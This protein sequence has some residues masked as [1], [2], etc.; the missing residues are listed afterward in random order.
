LTR[1][2]TMPLLEASVL[3]DRP[4]GEVWDYVTSAENLPVWVPVVHEVTKITD[5]PVGVGTQWQ[6]TMRFLGIGFTGLVE[7]VQCEINKMTEFKSVESK[8]RFSCTITFQEVDGRTRFTYRTETASGF[9]GIFGKL[10]RPIVSNASRR[11][12]RASLKNLAHVLS[13][14]G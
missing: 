8:F 6:G 11:T 5:G 13:V 7:F 12:L 4:V 3:I 10:A 2:R 1:G 14:K 9:D